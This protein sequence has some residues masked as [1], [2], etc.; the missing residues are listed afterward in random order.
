LRKQVRTSWCADR[1]GHDPELVNGEMF[2]EGI[3]FI[4]PQVGANARKWLRKV[5]SRQESGAG[6]IHVD[7]ASKLVM[8]NLGVGVD[9]NIC[10]PGNPSWGSKSDILG[11]RS[12]I[13][14]SRS[15]I[16]GSRSDILGSKSDLGRPDT[17]FR[18]E[19][20]SKSGPRFGQFWT[21]GSVETDPR[22]GRNGPQDRSKR[23]PGSVGS[24]PRI[25]RK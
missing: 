21:P 25:G 8:H 22:I 16:L 11:S 23:T 14:G 3:G 4:P 5:L 10:D 2:R 6:A 19:T 13:L 9:S 12:D 17:R 20:T 18:T 15:D 24:D 7:G 1:K